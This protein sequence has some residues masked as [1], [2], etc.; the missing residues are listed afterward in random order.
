[1]YET[2]EIIHEILFRLS[3]LLLI[4][5]II[6]TSTA[7]TRLKVHAHWLGAR[8]ICG[9]NQCIFRPHKSTSNW[10]DSS[11]RVHFFPSYRKRVPASPVCTNLLWFGLS[12]CNFRHQRVRF[13]SCSFKHSSRK[14]DISFYIGIYENV[15]YGP[16]NACSHQN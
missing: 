2:S 9:K 16:W 1:M 15:F 11:S 13:G 4:F 7:L 10:S 8:N 12:L 5:Y 6:R 14:H 3:L